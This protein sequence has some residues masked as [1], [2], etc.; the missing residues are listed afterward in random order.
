MLKFGPGACKFRL[1]PGTCKL[2]LG[3][4]GLSWGPGGCA[5]VGA[6]GL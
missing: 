4:G 6:W 2:K 1:E 3:P 5:S